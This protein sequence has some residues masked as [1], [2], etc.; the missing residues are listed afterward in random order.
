MDREQSTALLRRAREGAPDALDALYDRVAPRLLALVRL[1]LGRTLRAELESRD[2]V[3]ATFLKSFEHFKQFEQ[4]DGRSLMAWLARIAENE[5]RD[6]ADYHTRQRRDARVEL[7]LDSAHLAVPARMPSALTQLVLDERATR[8]EEALDA[9]EPHYREVIILRT[10]EELGF[11]EIGDRIGK[12][13]DASRM[14]FARAMAAL[15]V[16]MA[17]DGYRS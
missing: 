8:L 7:P 13:E 5:I 17:A 10:F 2:I 4:S 9:L 6:R 14:L 1:R 12:T 15:T 11:R 16:R 3:Q